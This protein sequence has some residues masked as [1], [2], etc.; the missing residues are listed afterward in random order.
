MEVFFNKDG[1]ALTQQFEL[2]DIKLPVFVVIKRGQ[3]IERI[4]AKYRSSYR[5]FKE[6]L[7]AACI[8]YN[9]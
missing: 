1:K 4:S 3:I 5:L 2:N 7:E 6:T 8:K 9:K